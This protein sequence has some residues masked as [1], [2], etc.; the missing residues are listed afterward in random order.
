MHNTLLFIIYH[1][2]HACSILISLL[3]RFCDF[4]KFFFVMHLTATVWSVCCTHYTF[5]VLTAWHLMTQYQTSLS[6]NCVISQYNVRHHYHIM[7]S[8]HYTTSDIN[9]I[10][11][12]KHL[13]SMSITTLHSTLVEHSITCNNNCMHAIVPSVL[14]VVN[15]IQ[16]THSKML[17]SIHGQTELHG[18][19]FSIHRLWTDLGVC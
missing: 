19:L 7:Q 6:C 10:S 9:V 8:S 14:H 12:Y 5:I 11:L 13:R 4:A 1:F 2:S 17:F 18:W 15:A 3:R 16:P